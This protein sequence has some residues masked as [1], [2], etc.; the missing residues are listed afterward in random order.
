M[1]ENKQKTA[2][3]LSLR[4]RLQARKAAVGGPKGDFYNVGDVVKDAY[5]GLFLF[6]ISSNHIL[7]I[8]FISSNH[9][10]RSRSPRGGRGG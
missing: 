8:F 5:G 10:V 1:S 9:G 4:K 2:K 7:S 3:V 6:F